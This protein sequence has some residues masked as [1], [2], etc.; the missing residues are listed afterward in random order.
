M[1]HTHSIAVILIYIDVRTF[2]YVWRGQDVLFVFKIVEFYNDR[3]CS[4]CLRT[5]RNSMRAFNASAIFS[6]VRIMCLTKS[7]NCCKFSAGSSCGIPAKNRLF[8]RDL[9]LIS[10][11]LSLSYIRLLCLHFEHMFLGS[12]LE[13][14]LSVAACLAVFVFIFS[15]STWPL[16]FWQAF[17]LLVIPLTLNLTV[18][19]VLHLQHVSLLQL[20]TLRSPL[21]S[22]QV[23]DL[24]QYHRIVVGQDDRHCYVA[25]PVS[26]LAPLGLRDLHLH[27]PIYQNHIDL[28]SSLQAST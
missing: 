2:E 9:S 24:I 25:L 8:L 15:C 18:F 22:V 16:W 23:Q 26:I 4:W 17:L 27:V 19:Q 10:S 14:F 20:P 6:F 1:Y 7:P 11:S 21:S 5:V 28:P 3:Y 13:V 12:L